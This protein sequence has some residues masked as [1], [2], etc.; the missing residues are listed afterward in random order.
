MDKVNCPIANIINI[1]RGNVVNSTLHAFQHKNFNAG[2]KID[3]A[4]VDAESNVEGVVDQ[5][6]PS[7]EY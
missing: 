5:W 1:H 6:G 7:R 2:A 4:F 3:V